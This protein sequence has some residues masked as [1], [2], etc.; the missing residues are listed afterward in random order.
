MT[1]ERMFLVVLKQTDVSNRGF[2]SGISYS[3]QEMA[4]NMKA[5][6]GTALDE[7]QEEQYG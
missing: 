5:S 7:E 3:C 6:Q 1:E 4:C 2:L